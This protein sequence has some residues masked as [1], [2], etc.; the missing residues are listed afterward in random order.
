[1]Q[2]RCNDLI[3]KTNKK[4]SKEIKSDNSKRSNKEKYKIFK[5]NNFIRHQKYFEFSGTNNIFADC[6][7]YLFHIGGCI[8]IIPHSMPC[9]GLDLTFYMKLFL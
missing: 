3:Y 4:I 5:N 6:I 8:F 9:Q 7:V 1:M 2:K